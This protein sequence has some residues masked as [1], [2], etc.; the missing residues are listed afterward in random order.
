[1]FIYE[2]METGMKAELSEQLA[3]LNQNDKQMDDLYHHYALRL[4]ISDTV[5]WILYITYTQ[6]DGLT[7]KEICDLWAYSKQTINTALKH[8]EA[9]GILALTPVE[10]HRKSKRI[11]FTERGRQYARETIEPLVRAEMTSLKKMSEEERELLVNLSLKWTALF[12]QELE[13]VKN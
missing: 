12:Q 3:L 1:M 8:L 5:L 9:E 2:R 6:G 7:Q 4:G 10:G 11:V 13:K